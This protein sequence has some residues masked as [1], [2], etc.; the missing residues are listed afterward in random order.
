M[1]DAERL[2]LS[3]G[4]EVD[5][6]QNGATVRAQVT[7]RERVEQGVCFLVE[8]TA[9]GNANQLLNGGPVAVEI[10]KVTA[11]VGGQPA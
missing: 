2:G 10:T 7:I 8:G 11:A 4:D 1:S 9:E 3:S 6:S 5:V